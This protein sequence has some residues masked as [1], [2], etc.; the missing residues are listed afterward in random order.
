MSFKGALKYVVFLGKGFQYSAA[1]DSFMYSFPYLSI[2]YVG[3]TGEP[4]DRL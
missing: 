2:F 3:G 4:K 1:A